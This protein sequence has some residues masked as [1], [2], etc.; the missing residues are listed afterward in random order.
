MQADRH[1]GYVASRELTQVPRPRG[2][3][4]GAI[5]GH[6]PPTSL[7]ESWC[8]NQCDATVKG[9]QIGSGPTEGTC[10]TLTAKLKG[11]GMRWDDK[12]AEASWPSRL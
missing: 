9:W 12:N 7:P 1:S 4:S 11:S 5:G 10:K 8:M 6:N 3:G 2:E